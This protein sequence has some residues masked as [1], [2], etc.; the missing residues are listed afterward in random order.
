MVAA[1]QKEAKYNVV[2]TV[3][4][5]VAVLSCLI[6]A[7]VANIGGVTFVAGA[8][9]YAISFTC[10]SIIFECWGKKRAWRTLWLGFLACAIVVV[11]TELSIRLP[12]S[13][14]WPNQ[15]AYEKTLGATWRLF[16]AGNIA[17]WIGKGTE[18]AMLQFLMRV[19]KGRAGLLWVRDNG[20]VSVAQVVDTVV[21]ICGAFYGVLPTEVLWRIGVSQLLVKLIVMVCDDPFVY[22]AR[23]WAGP[24]EDAP[25]RK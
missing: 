16:I 1:L 17:F 10:V 15:E 22:M 9:P 7:K 23:R 19:T 5:T 25:E 14:R 12:P 18:I 11:I 6:S 13:P 21:F 3:F 4:I 8:I 20:A 2:L 24:A